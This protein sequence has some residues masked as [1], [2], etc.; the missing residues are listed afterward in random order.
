MMQPLV[1]VILPVYNA[2]AYITEA[3]Q[4]VLNQTYSNFELIVINDG[5]TDD[6]EALIK[7]FTDS[8]IRYYAQTNRG[9][10][11][12]LNVALGYCKAELIARQ[13]QDDVSYP[14]RFE[15]Q[16]AY[17]LSHPEVVLLGTR[18]R[19]VT[20]SGAVYGY[21]L[22]AS[23][24]AVLKLDMV[25][26]NPF[27]HSSVIFRKQAV[28]AVGGYN[29]NRN[30][31]EDYDLWSKLAVHG[32]VANL[33]EV[34]LDY[35]HHQQGM[36]KHTHNFKDSALYDQGVLNLHTYFNL[37]GDAYAL[38]PA[39]FH[40]KKEKIGSFSYRQLLQSLQVVAQKLIQQYPAESHAI[41]A[42]KRYYQKL[43]IYRL[44]KLLQEESAHS[45]LKLL[46][47]K[48]EGRLWKLLN[49]WYQ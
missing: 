17:L 25:F 2:A 8:R 47:S 7:Q 23:D 45:P 4:S 6:S 38:L 39:V 1:S 21:H 10:G 48:V 20:D 3:I 28:M 30:I 22:H 9:L 12:T 13:D 24:N 35:R 29:P 33:P 11:A 27:V 40:F 41:R 31:Y 5:S 18:A 16:V 42:R 37:Q 14:Q 34:L 44:N 49:L 46:T 32:H 43:L 15:K 36:S 19:I 26:D